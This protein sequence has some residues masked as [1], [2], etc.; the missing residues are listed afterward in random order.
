M[1]ALSKKMDETMVLRGFSAKTRS[2]YVC[3]VR[4]LA[5]YDQRSPDRISKEEIERYLLH[6]LE[7]KGLSYSPCN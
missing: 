2:A 6:L 3:R 4:G 1:S 7:E 5:Q